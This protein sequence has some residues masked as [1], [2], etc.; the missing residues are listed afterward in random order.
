MF[1]ANLELCIMLTKARGSPRGVNSSPAA[2][3]DA[4]SRR[5][6]LQHHLTAETVKPRRAPASSGR[7][8]PGSLDQ[9][10]LLDQPPEILLMQQRA[11]DSLDRLLQVVKGELGREQLE[12]HGAVFQLAPE[13]SEGSGEDA[14]M[15][16][17]HR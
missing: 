5:R 8:V 7:D 2:R 1:R 17:S 6:A 4:E 3:L 14:A 15:V 12:H 11:G 9:A 10:A 13:P 16:E